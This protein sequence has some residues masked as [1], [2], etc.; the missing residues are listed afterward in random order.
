MCSFKH[1]HSLV[2]SATM[3]HKNLYS[4]CR[5]SR[6]I[7]CLF[8]QKEHMPLHY[9]LNFT[10]LPKW[11]PLM[12]AY[13]M[14]SGS[15]TIYLNSM[16]HSHV[17]FWWLHSQTCHLKLPSLSTGQF[18]I[19]LLASFHHCGATNEDKHLF[20]YFQNSNNQRQ[21][22]TNIKQRQKLSEK[23]MHC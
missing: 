15:V 17:P 10:W 20:S 18:H 2:G 4:R 1:C 12:L 16:I 3:L 19:K 13:R 9:S 22:T 6:S 23:I 21:H 8:N 11:N 14:P 5:S 7:W